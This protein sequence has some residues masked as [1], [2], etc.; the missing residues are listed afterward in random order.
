MNILKQVLK[1]KNSMS[2]TANCNLLDFCC[3]TI[4]MSQLSLHQAL[5]P[6]VQTD[7]ESSAQITVI[8]LLIENKIVLL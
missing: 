1:Q 5:F 3:L 2:L 6:V 4:Y 8:D 7:L